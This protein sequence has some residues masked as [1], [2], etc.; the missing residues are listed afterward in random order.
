MHATPLRQIPQE[1]ESTRLNIHAPQINDAPVINK[2]ISDSFSEISQ[3]LPWA[4]RI[5][6]LEESFEHCKDAH[7]KY[8]KGEDLQLLL[9][10]K[11]TGALIGSSGL[12]RIDW[13]VPKFE[14]GYWCHSHHLGKGFIT[15]S[16]LRI[17]QF[18]FNDLK[19]NRV[20]IKMDEKNLKSKSIPERLGFKLDGILRN[21][22]LNNQGQLSNTLVYSVLKITDLK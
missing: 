21:D 22:R 10:E 3:W 1:F 6:T 8:L 7:E 4:N 2:A 16:T 15:E 13:S 14:I 17:A 11:A 18:A 20:E 19:A 12:H 9:F 5:P